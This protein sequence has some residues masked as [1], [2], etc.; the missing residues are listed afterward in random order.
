VNGG[1]TPPVITYLLSLTFVM[2]WSI[3]TPFIPLYLVARGATPTAVGV[4]VSLSGILPLV[5]SVHVGALV[6]THGPASVGKWS[7][8][9]NAAACA[10]FVALPSMS[11]VAVAYALLGLGNLGLT[12]STQTVVAE[13]SAPEERAHSFG[14]YSSWISAGMVLGPIL[15][16]LIADLWG[17]RAVFVSVL[18]LAAPAIVLASQVR[19]RPWQ[20]KQAARLWAAHRSVGSILRL[21]GVGL[22]QFISFMVACGLSL[23]QSFYPLYLQNVGLSTTLIGL[24]LGAGSLSSMLVRPFVGLGVSRFGYATLLAAATGLATAAIGIT[25]FLATFTPLMLASLALGA[26][27]GFT[28]PLTM[29]LMADA[30]TADLWG[31]AMGVRQSAQRLATVMSPIAFGV[32]ITRFGLGSAFFL[33]AL[34]M[35]AAMVVIARLGSQLGSHASDVSARGPLAASVIARDIDGHGAEESHIGKGG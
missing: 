22:V 33:G 28:Q 5:F 12:L 8:C 15:G 35:G 32:A 19:S 11:G 20:P 24:I 21:P 31:L 13:S 14:Y 3:A 16:G 2:M 6:D 17:Y 18:V 9:A 29:S 34:A 23:R 7:V 10:M 30:V 26:S 27:T 4:V 1:R 25:P